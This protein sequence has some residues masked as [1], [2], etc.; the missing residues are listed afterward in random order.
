MPHDRMLATRGTLHLDQQ[1]HLP[2]RLPAL[3]RGDRARSPRRDTSLRVIDRLAFGAHYAETLRQW[4][5][6]VP[7]RARPGG[8]RSASTRRSGGCGTSTWSTPAPGFASGLPRREAAGAGAMTT[9]KV[10]TGEVSTGSTG[11]AQRLESALRPFLRRRPAGAAARLGRLGGRPG[12]RAAGGAP[13]ARR[14]TPDAVAAGRARR[15]AG[16]RHRRARRGR[17]PRGGARAR[18]RGRPRARAVGR[19]AHARRRCCARCAPPPASGRSAAR[20]PRPRPRP[21]VRGRLHSRLR[22]RRGDQPPLRP[23]QR[24]LRAAARRDDGLLL[25]LLDRPT[26]RRTTSGE[27]QRDKLD[28]VCR[29][30]GLGP[31]S[32]LL[33]VGCG[34]GSL[35]LHA[36]EH[37]GARVTGHHDRR[38]AEGVHRRADPRARARRAGRDPAAGLPRRGRRPST[39]SARSR[40]ASTS[41]RTTTRRTSTSCGSALRPGGRVLVQQMSRTGRHPG[42]G[43]FIESFIAPDMHMRP[44]GDDRRATSRRGASRCAT[45]TPCASTTCGP[46]T[47]GSSGSRPTSPALIDLVG[48]EAVRVWRLYLVGGRLAFR[49][50]RMGVDQILCVR[51]GGAPDRPEVR[52]W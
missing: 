2:R 51:P 4:D 26:T 7:G 38:G 21:G 8:R 10:P 48:E 13:L 39:P 43:P 33:D 12:R 35:S 1:V 42:G 11:V 19:P 49:D 29:K 50:G 18:V 47:A 5:E 28:L 3:G 37:F 16:L 15:R 24:L 22:D 40:W 14:R 52:T 27:A 6:R 34:W 17:R 31:G 20:R 23:V 25:R 41:A 36:A 30:L 44:V 9:T 45:C 32:T 46:S